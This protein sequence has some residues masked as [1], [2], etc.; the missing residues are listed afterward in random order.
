MDKVD[1]NNA[2]QKLNQLRDT[3][4]TS[5]TDLPF[6]LL[7]RRNNKA[8]KLVATSGATTPMDGANR[9][10]DYG[11]S[12]PVF[13]SEIVVSMENYSSLDT[14]EMKWELA[15]GGTNHRDISRGSDT[16]YRASV[17]QLVK[18]ISF[19]PPRKWFTN[20]KLN[21]VSLVGFQTKELDEFV[22]LV[23]RLERFKADIVEDS[24][25][26]IR[27]AQEANNKLDALRQE[28][29][30]LNGQ[31]TEAKGTVTD[32]NN[33]IGR[34]TEE[35]N[36]LVADVK[37]REETVTTLGE[38]EVT[39]KE[40]ITERNAERSALAAEIAEM[41][42]ELRSLQ[43][44]INMF[45]TEISGFVSQAAKNTSMYWWLSVVP[46][47][48]LVVM[49]ALLVSNAAN[50]TTV[51]DE[52]ENA[53]IFSILVTRIPYVVIATAIIG[54]AYKLATLFVGEIM[55][56]NQQRLNLSKVSIIAT[57]VSKASAEGLEDL[58]D[59]EIFALRTRLKMDMLR[60]H[61]KEYL[62]KDFAA[63]LARKRREANP[64]T[65][66]EPNEVPHADES[67]NVEA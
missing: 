23:T 64:K 32:L 41:K 19:K 55:R 46:I 66:E 44:D 27:S 4:V 42:Q 59:E 5:P 35:R 11:F 54:A 34:L 22:R 7:N 24:E 21:S 38:Q 50:L 36:G 30:Q 53:R 52:H 57:D 14:F 18:S 39:V 58:S 8:T 17:N 12:E 33:Q 37:K 62:S 28:R 10:F 51:I 47:V 40:R 6:D 56:I 25:R 13:L 43:D 61:M 49:A 31:I 65:S 63:S 1:L 9:W 15:Q 45:P 60:D 20:P 26:A 2:N 48:L 67:D 3:T 16:A 29:D